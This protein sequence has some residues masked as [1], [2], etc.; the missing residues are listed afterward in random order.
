MTAE[1]IAKAL[2]GRKASSGCI[3]RYPAHDERKPSLSIGET[4]DRR[5]D[6][7]ISMIM[8]SRSS[9]LAGGRR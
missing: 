3:A 6:P 9:R 5:A 2:V 8:A 7:T 4:K 1:S